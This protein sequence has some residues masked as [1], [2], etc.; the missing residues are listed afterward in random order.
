MEQNDLFNIENIQIEK[1]NTNNKIIINII[2]LL[3]IYLVI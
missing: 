1:Q 2:L 3:L